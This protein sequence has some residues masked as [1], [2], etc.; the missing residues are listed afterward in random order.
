MQRFD[1]LSAREWKDPKTT[2]P[3][4]L[5]IYATA[6]YDFENMEQSIDIF[7]GQSSGHTYSRYGN[8]TVEATASKIAAMESHGSDINAQ[9]VMTSSGMSALHVLISGLLHAGDKILTQANIYGGSTELL[10]LM[11]KHWGIE[12]VYTD[13]SQTEKVDEILRKDKAIKL[14]FFETPANPTLACI[15]I[16]TLCTV[17]R[18]NQIWSA[19]D[20]TF[21]T[22]YLQQPML[23]GSDFIIH[24][25]SKFLN[26]HGT[27]ISG[28]VVG[29]DDDFFKEHIWK[30]MKLTGANCSPFESWLV[31]QGLKT[32]PLRMQKHSQNAMALAHVLSTHKNV[33][34]V[35]YPGLKNHPSHA[36]AKNQMRA[37]GGMMSFELNG[38]IDA[39]LKA[40]NRM[41]FCS[42]TPTLGD[43]DTMILHPASS[44]HLRVDPEV[45]RQVGITDGLI[46]VSVG[47]E[48]ETDIIADVLQ[49]IEK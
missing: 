19:I 46:R 31:Y 43:V 2:E 26:G 24:S 38:G 49:A 39:A 47:I 23:L 35:N 33:L 14:V 20:N 28:I 4:I 27:T 45:R 29:R 40:M 13:L 9:A 42:L 18:E 16:K 10:H 30:T 41:Q 1:S 5:P 11:R 36:V 25:T 12:L 34:H 32:L 44:S 7:S 3:H 37:F 17:A 48:D 22:P 6:S 8:P 21:A 15:D